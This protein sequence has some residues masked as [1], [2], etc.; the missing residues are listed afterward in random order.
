MGKRMILLDT[1]VAHTGAHSRTQCQ[2]RFATRAR[3]FD[4]GPSVEGFTGR[5]C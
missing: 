5:T 1:S 4:A 3:S 2:A